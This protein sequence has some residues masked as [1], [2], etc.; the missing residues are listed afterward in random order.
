MLAKKVG[1]YITPLIPFFAYTF[2]EIL[3][4]G[5]NTP[6]SILNQTAATSTPHPANPRPSTPPSLQRLA[7]ELK[8]LKSSQ[9]SNKERVKL[10][11]DQ[12]RQLLSHMA[13]AKSEINWLEVELGRIGGSQNILDRLRELKELHEWAGGKWRGLGDEVLEADGEIAMP[14][15]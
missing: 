5:G 7:R 3:G 14:G 15:G 6:I 13:S 10:L 4:V 8:E 2:A 11:H 12:R 1:L 9:L